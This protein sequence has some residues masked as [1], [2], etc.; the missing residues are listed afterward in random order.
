MNTLRLTYPVPL[1]CRVLEVSR[2]GYYAWLKR[3]PSKR[4]QEE[5]RLENEIKA[6]HR[7]TRET[8]GP[9]RLQAELAAHGVKVGN[10][11]D[12]TDQEE[13]RASLQAGQEIQ[14][15]DTLNAQASGVGESAW[16]EL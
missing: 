14:G 11:P 1:V 7:R 5:G 12:Q 16:P 9:E 8:C 3:A 6:A 13:A 15:D 2:S 4:A 10:L